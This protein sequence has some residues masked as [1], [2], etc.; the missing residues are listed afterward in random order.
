MY[1]KKIEEP[2]IRFQKNLQ[3]SPRRTIQK[4]YNT[5]HMRIFL[6]SAILIA[7]VGCTE[8]AEKPSELLGTWETTWVLVMDNAGEMNN[9]MFDLFFA[10]TTNWERKMG[11]K[12]IRT[13]YNADGTFTGEYRDLRD[14]VYAISSG[15]WEVRGESL[16][17]RQM[18]PDTFI[19]T[20]WF[21]VKDDTLRTRGIIDWARDGIANDKFEGTQKLLK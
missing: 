20:Y 5:V 19:A 8:P 4:E 12:P 10:D 21:I 18:E 17:F 6:F 15:S 11:M 1:E 14:S 13:T 2:R 9:E 3:R 7:A 16:Y